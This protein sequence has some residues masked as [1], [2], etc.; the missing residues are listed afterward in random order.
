MKD[1][2]EVRSESLQPIDLGQVI[3]QPLHVGGHG[4]GLGHVGARRVEARLVR[5]VLDA[6]LQPVRAQYSCHVIR[7]IQSEAGI[8]TDLLPLRGHEAVAAANG[9]RGPNLLSAG[10]VIIGKTGNIKYNSHINTYQCDSPLT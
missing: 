10:P 4:R 6:D 7:L 2:G 1:A 5:V 9:V 8:L 3:Q